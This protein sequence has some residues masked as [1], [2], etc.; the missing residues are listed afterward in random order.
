MY[1]IGKTGVGKST[2]IANM[3]S[4][5]IESGYGLAVIDPHGDLAEE[6]LDAV[7]ASRVNDVIY[8]NPSDLEYP[9]GIQPPGAC[10]S[11]SAPPGSFGS[12]LDLQESLA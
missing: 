7:P 1:L 2:L 11:R 8:L 6:I 5:D 4:A 10:R 12:H 3:A 9:V